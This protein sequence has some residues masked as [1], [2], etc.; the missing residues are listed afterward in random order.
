MKKRTLIFV[1][2]SCLAP[3]MFSHVQAQTSGSLVADAKPGWA[4]IS[5]NIV[6]A[7]EKMP[8]EHWSYKPAPEV[9][10]FGAIVAH[11]ADGNYLICGAANGEK[12]ELTVEKTKSSKADIIA[13]LKESMAY[14]DAAYDGGASTATERSDLVQAIVDWRDAGAERGD[15]RAKNAPFY[16]VDEL[17]QVPGMDET[18][19][20]SIAPFLTVF[21]GDAG[22]DFRFA[23]EELVRMLK[24][25]AQTSAR[26]DGE[27]E[28]LPPVGVMSIS[29]VGAVDDVR[30]HIAAVV[31]LTGRP[32]PPYEILSWH[33]AV[34]GAL[35]N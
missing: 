28:P 4:A 33:E 22:P 10:S 14:C 15:E 32:S 21:G 29:S 30:A 13:A 11:V 3:A 16:S 18:T 26:G 8:E 7:A 35:E 20:R 19:F 6:K 1:A 25:T 12:R 9:R 24:A 34:P 27:P 2:V 17:R 5:A 23:S 31:Y